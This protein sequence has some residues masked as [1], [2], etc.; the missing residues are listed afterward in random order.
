MKKILFIM[1]LATT[2]IPI[3]QTGASLR[4]MDVSDKFKAKE[5]QTITKQVPGNLLKCESQPAPEKIKSEE[6]AK[7]SI[8]N[9]QKLTK[10][11]ISSERRDRLFG[12]LLLAHGGQR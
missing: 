2:F 9:R 7:K 1:I 10:K 4:D 6:R 3:T 11:K 8:I 12:L 5:A